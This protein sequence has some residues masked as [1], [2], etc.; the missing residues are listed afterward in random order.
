MLLIGLLLTATAAIGFPLRRRIYALAGAA[1]LSPSLSPESEV[2]QTVHFTYRPVIDPFAFPA[3]GL[4]GPGAADA[5]RVMALATLEEYA[6]H[7][8]VVIP[9]ADATAIFGLADDELLD[10]TTAGLFIPGNLDAALASI[11]TELVVRRDTQG[12]DRPA[13]RLLLLADCEKEPER[14]QDLLSNHPGDVS[15]LLLGDWPADQV[16][17]D[18]DGLVTAPTALAGCLP[19]RFPAMSRTE[20]R[21]RL[22]AAIGSHRP[23]RGTH[24]KRRRRTTPS[25]S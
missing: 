17:V 11:E 5:A 15:A 2:D 10:E 9:R 23:D 14:I 6:E 21:D 25:P 19:E 3:V 7:A 22:H 20:A 13:P 12:R 1:L 16:T 8:L 4:T 18:D 24:A